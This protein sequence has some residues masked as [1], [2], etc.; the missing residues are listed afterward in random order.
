[1]KDLKTKAFW[2]SCVALTLF[3]ISACGSAKRAPTPT[4]RPLTMF[5]LADSPDVH[6]VWSRHLDGYISDLNLSKQGNALLVATLPD[7]DHPGGSHKNLIHYYDAG[8]HERWRS[9][10]ATQVKS[11]AIS[12]NG[13]LVLAATHEDQILAYDGKSKGKHLWTIDATCTPF[14]IESRHEIVCYHDDDAGPDVAFD[15]LDWKG[16]KKSSY[17][18]KNDILTMKVAEDET[19]GH[20]ADP[21]SDFC[22][23]S[24]LPGAL[25]STSSGRDCG[26][27]RL[28]R[29]QASSGGSLFDPKSLAATKRRRDREWI[30]GLSRR[31]NQF[32]GGWKFGADVWKRRGRAGSESDVALRKAT[33]GK[34]EAR[35]DRQ[36]S[37]YIDNV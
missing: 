1:M 20:R 24:G 27:R 32:F 31:S 5:Q 30:P 3:G 34:L 23:W 4:E 18:I 19:P 2:V 28:E 17:A 21:R 8:G 13:S 6:K 14:I 16:N 33:H 7:F 36:R 26:S 15:V 12:S 35:G 22:F 11:Q 10:M 9:V 25:V 37:L 29:R